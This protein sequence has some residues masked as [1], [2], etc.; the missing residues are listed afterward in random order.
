MA[1]KKLP[2]GN[3]TSEQ[4]PKQSNTSLQAQTPLTLFLIQKIIT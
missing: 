3:Q 4:Q 2:T 1:T